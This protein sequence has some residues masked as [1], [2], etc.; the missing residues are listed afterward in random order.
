[1]KKVLLTAVLTVCMVVSAMAQTV[2]VDSLSKVRLGSR[3]NLTIDFSQAT[4]HDRS[5][6]EF[7]KY[8][9]DWNDDKPSVVE[10]FRA[11]ANFKLDNE[12]KLGFY[13]DADYQMTVTVKNISTKGFIVCD[14]VLTDNSGKVFLKVENLKGSSDSFFTPG[15]KLAR[16]K[17]WAALTGG[18]LG[19][20]MKDRM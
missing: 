3:A 18:A 15:T 4:I 13:D 17:F 16:I 6:A 19:T 11:A 5:E 7:A 10:K 20:I 9:K 1:M 2:T 12:M 14:A 8:E